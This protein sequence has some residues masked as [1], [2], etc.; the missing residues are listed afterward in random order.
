[1][2]GSRKGERRGGRRS[3]AE[4]T[5]DASTGKITQPRKRGAPKGSTNLIT[6]EREREMLEVIT[7][8]REL[9]PKDILLASTRTLFGLAMDYQQMMLGAIASVPA[10]E[11][12]RRTL[13]AT[14]D[15]AEAKMT[16][17]LLLAS[18]VSRDLSP[19]IHPRLAALAVTTDRNTEGDLFDLLLREIDQAPRLRVIEHRKSETEAA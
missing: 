19:Y 10:N 14:V 16:Q 7:G 2:A 18:Q 13:N 17:Y 9:M 5:F 6:G 11:E 12:Q 15:H 1:M 3:T 8:E 4:P